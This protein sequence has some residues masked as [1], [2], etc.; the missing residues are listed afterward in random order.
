MSIEP[1]VPDNDG[2][3]ASDPW[4]A[5]P[6]VKKRRSPRK[7]LER[8]DPAD[9]TETTPPSKGVAPHQSDDLSSGG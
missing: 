5:F 7:H 6:V 4:A 8:S 2:V 9:R 3:S 1:G